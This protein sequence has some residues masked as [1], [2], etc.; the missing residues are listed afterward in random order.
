MA[1]Y[2]SDSTLLERFVSRREEAAF[3]DLVKRH[4]PRVAGTCRQLLR[5]EQDV[6]DVFQATFLVLAHKAAGMP[7]RESVGSWL[8]AVARRLAMNARV[9][10]CASSS[11]T[12]PIRHSGSGRRRPT[13]R[14]IPSTGRTLRGYRT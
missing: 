12:N 11:P 6:E 3:D 7:W 5:N 1:K 14:A 4:G 9:D 13:S 2:V 8:C 10:A